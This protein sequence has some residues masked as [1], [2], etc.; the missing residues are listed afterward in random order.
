MELIPYIPVG[1]TRDSY[2]GPRWYWPDQPHSLFMHGLGYVNVRESKPLWPGA[3]GGLIP[4]DGHRVWKFG[5]Q[6][7]SEQ[8]ADLPLRERNFIGLSHALQVMAYLAYRYDYQIN[9]FLSVCGPVRK[10]MEPQYYALARQCKT[11]RHVY[12]ADWWMDWTQILGSLFDGGARF[13]R[14]ISIPGVI[15]TP[16]KQIT[17]SNT[18]RDPKHFMDL[19]GAILETF[20]VRMGDFEV[21]Q[22]SE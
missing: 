11:W 22:H 8:F 4:G 17:H 9:S 12:V 15:D 3:T 19:R 1:G 7:M 21:T 20:P 18:V 6:Y 14:S 16:L 5:A 13:R 10:D 2:S